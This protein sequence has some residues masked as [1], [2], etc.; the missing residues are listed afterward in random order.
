[1]SLDLDVAKTA[2]AIR[3]GV[4]DFGLELLDPRAISKADTELAVIGFASMVCATDLAHETVRDG[5]SDFWG[6]V[7]LNSASEAMDKWGRVLGVHRDDGDRNVGG[8]STV[9]LRG[10]DVT[11][12]PYGVVEIGGLE[13]TSEDEAKRRFT[14]DLSTTLAW[15]G[16]G[17]LGGQG[18]TI[19]EPQAV[20]HG[21]GLGL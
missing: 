20:D 10:I 17:P 9:S 11:Y 19:D 12:G 4:S 3:S 18:R 15:K 6:V 13:V 14:V 7:E 1:M 21:S 5:K 2:R 8:L 16:G